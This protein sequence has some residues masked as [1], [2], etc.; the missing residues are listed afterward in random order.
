MQEQE[1]YQHYDPYCPACGGCGEEGCC[2]PLMCQQDEKGSYCSGYLKD[3]KFG[4]YM[5]QYFE[6]NIWN[7]MP[8]DLKE[9]YDQEFDKALEK[10]YR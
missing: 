8:E 1:Q 6:Q 9:E 4:Y 7:R 10:F 5:N 3:L 2:S